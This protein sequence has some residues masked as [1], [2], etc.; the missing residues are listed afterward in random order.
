MYAGYTY[1]M[2]TKKTPGRPRGARTAKPTKAISLRVSVDVADALEAYA[3][4]LRPRATVSSVGALALEEFLVRV[5]V[6]LPPA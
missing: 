4:T 5:G 1:G 2:T 3:A 6:K